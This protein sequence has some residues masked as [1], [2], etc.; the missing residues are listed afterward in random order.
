M[1]IGDEEYAT[2]LGFGDARLYCMEHE[3][4]IAV[5][6]NNVEFYGF[7]NA[8]KQ[9]IVRGVDD[10]LEQEGIET[11]DEQIELFLY[12]H[13]TKRSWDSTLAELKSNTG[14]RATTL[15][16]TTYNTPIFIPST[17]NTG[18]KGSES[19]RYADAKTRSLSGT[20]ESLIESNRPRKG[21]KRRWSIGY[22]RSI[23]CKNPRG[24]SQRN[25]CKRQRRGG[26]YT[27]S[28][29]EWLERND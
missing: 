23:N 15:P 2:M 26:R 8:K 19:P 10:I 29:K 24:F 9:E 5:R 7:D 17:N 20:S 6:S 28:F 22:K 14:V 13:K 3:G 21:M 18:L 4:W 16:N 12:D 1:G 25:Y 11:P 27:E